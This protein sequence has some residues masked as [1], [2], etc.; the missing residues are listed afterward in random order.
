MYTNDELQTLTEKWSE[1]RKITIN[2]KIEMQLI[3]LMEEVGELAAAVSR[4][5]KLAFEDAIGD[6]CVLLTNIAK[7]NQTSLNKCWNS[8]YQEIKDRKG[9]LLPNGNFVKEGDTYDN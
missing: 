7:L 5:K 1:D 6:C 2:G 4:N 9:T 3:K 8:A